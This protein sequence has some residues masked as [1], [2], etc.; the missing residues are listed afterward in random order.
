M[1]TQCIL[2][3]LPT[4]IHYHY[5]CHYHHHHHH[6]NH[7]HHRDHDRD[8][9]DHDHHSH[10]HHKDHDNDLQMPCCPGASPSD[11]TAPPFPGYAWKN[12][13]PRLMLV[14]LMLMLMVKLK[15][16]K[17]TIFRVRRK[18]SVTWLSIGSASPGKDCLF[19]F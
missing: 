4:I 11:P 17:V 9:F 7:Q 6:S 3:L 1:Q 10:D 2:F 13:V 8:H 18:R 16:V 15:H 19:V 12:K 5:L 14:V